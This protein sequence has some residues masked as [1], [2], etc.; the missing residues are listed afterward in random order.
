MDIPYYCYDILLSLSLKGYVKGTNNLVNIKQN[1]CIR[2]MYKDFPDLPAKYA[3]I[4]DFIMDYYEL[5]VTKGKSVNASTSETAELRKI[6][7][8]CYSNDI[9]SALSALQQYK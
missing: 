3:N 1:Q 7:K 2:G 5:Y 9:V 6:V 4:N 8:A